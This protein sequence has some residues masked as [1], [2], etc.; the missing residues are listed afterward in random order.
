VAPGWLSQVFAE[1]TS[2]LSSSSSSLFLLLSSFLFSARDVSFRRRAK[3]AYVYTRV[4]SA[5][6]KT[7]R[8]I[9]PCQVS[10]TQ[11]DGA[12]RR[13]MP[14]VGHNVVSTRETCTSPRRR[15]TAKNAISRSYPVKK[16]AGRKA[17]YVKPVASSVP[18]TR[19]SVDPPS[20]KDPT[21]EHQP[22]QAANTPVRAKT[23]LFF[24]F[25]A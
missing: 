13:R 25:A 3:K 23:R 17:E 10:I 6:V 2:G 9:P 7:Y 4:M 14:A 1:A 12:T 5:Y 22:E 20:Q 8:Y 16:K 15:V 24:R 11:E 18:P 21:V 19:V